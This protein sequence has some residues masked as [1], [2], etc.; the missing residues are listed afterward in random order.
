MMLRFY[1]INFVEEAGR[2]KNKQFAVIGIG[3]FG[4]SLIKE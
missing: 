2:M 3:R 4:E 1:N